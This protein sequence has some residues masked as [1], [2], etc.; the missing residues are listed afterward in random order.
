MIK[1][2]LDLISIIIIVLICF[3]TFFRKFGS[4]LPNSL[5]KIL[6]LLVLIFI[7]LSFF[8]TQQ[9]QNFGS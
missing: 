7:T 9:I 4:F 6:A 5:N 2:I 8:Y 3:S 1:L